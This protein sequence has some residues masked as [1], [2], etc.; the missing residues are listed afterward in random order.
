MAHTNPLE[1]SVAALNQAQRHWNERRQAANTALA[2]SQA[3][4]IAVAREAGTPGTSVAHAVGARLGWPVYDH[5]LLE[6]IARETGW[7]VRLLESVDEKKQ[8]WL[9]ESLEALSTAPAENNDGLV[10]ESAY[11][12]HL[13]ETVLSLGV[14]GQCVIVG[15]GAAQLL[16]AATTLRVR[17][18]AALS[19][20]VA[21]VSQRLNLTRAEAERHVTETERERVRFVRDHFQKDPTDPRNY[22]LLLNASRWSVAEC[23]ELILHALHGMEVRAIFGA[24]RPAP[25]SYFAG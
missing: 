9:R 14:H 21:A 25:P 5:E 22:D 6:L 23:A 2:G 19:D 7:R 15:R 4:T 10:T 20:R 18:V 16:P 17:L 1:R 11:V 24:A 3:L 8:S 13:V 12:H